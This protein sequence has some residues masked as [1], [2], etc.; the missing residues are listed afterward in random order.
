MLVM[1]WGA[2]NHVGCITTADRTGGKK[3]ELEEDMFIIAGANDL[4][5]LKIQ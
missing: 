1:V 2:A 4:R 5:G 3:R